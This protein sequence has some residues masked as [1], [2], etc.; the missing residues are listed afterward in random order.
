M[1]STNIVSLTQGERDKF[2]A[3]LRQEAET[4]DVM[5][6]ELEKLSGHDPMVKIMR[7]RAVVFLLVAKELAKIEDY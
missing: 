1:S 6:R 5:S 2:G 7:T 3:W 4:D